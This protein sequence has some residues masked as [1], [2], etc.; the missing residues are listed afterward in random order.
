MNHN[1]QYLKNSILILLLALTCTITGCK[2]S[3]DNTVNNPLVGNWIIIGTGN[4]YDY[5]ISQTGVELYFCLQEDGTMK[6]ML[7]GGDK[8]ESLWKDGILYGENWLEYNSYQWSCDNGTITFSPAFWGDTKYTYKLISNDILEISDLVVL[9][10]IKSL[11][12]Y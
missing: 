1:K 11:V 12:K 10:R 8:K 2:K 7:Y 4:E 6:E 5:N 9:G 3:N